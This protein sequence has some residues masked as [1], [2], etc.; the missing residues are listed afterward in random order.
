M[1]LL[2]A[3]PALDV[4]EKH[5]DRHDFDHNQLGKGYAK[6]HKNEVSAG[7]IPIYP[8]RPKFDTRPNPGTTNVCTI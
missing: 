3:S 1:R 8:P 5:F 7:I 2:T 6:N 4:A